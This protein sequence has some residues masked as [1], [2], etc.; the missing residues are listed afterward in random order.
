M[1]DFQSGFE[2]STQAIE[3][4]VNTQLTKVPQWANIPGGLSKTSSSS[5]AGFVWGYNDENTLWRCA[6][7]C[8]GNWQEIAFNGK[9][10]DLTTDTTNVYVL[11]DQG[12]SISPANGIQ[13]LT[14]PIP[15]FSP[16]EVFSTHTFIWVQDASGNKL[17]CA[18]PC[19]AGVWQASGDATV[20]I[21]STSD[22]A[23]Y[24]IDAGGISMRTDE[25]MQTGWTPIK[26]LEKT[27]V[28]KIIGQMDT[29]ALY[30]IDQASKPFRC[31]GQDCSEASQVDTAGYIPQSLSA[32]PISKDIWMTTTTY[33][34]LG[35]IFNRVDSPD[36]STIMNKI[37][38][39]DKER[40]EIIGEVENEYNVQ[41]RFMVVEKQITDFIDYFKT[42]FKLSNQTTKQNKDSVGKLEDDI[43][44]SQIK[45]DTINSTQPFLQTIL[46]TLFIVVIM[47]VF[48]A[49]IL[50]SLIHMIA[51]VVL[52][53]GLY[54]A[55]NN[56]GQS[57]IFSSS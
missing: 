19:S 5:I 55:M 45:L 35:N 51:I 38:P 15:N 21:T 29:T 30:G 48:L 49:S 56:N 14:I 44:A 42:K 6:V 16:V 13:F 31:V 52:L 34:P 39:L 57:A 46:V 20:K 18:K 25:T 10:L 37:A 54:Y 32:D 28:S 3:G 7:P 26:G 24:G 36:Y 53:G 41:T 47:Y 33:A 1:A 23:L 17:R 40:Q 22:S 9:I 2:E 11:S 43:R 27:P 12:L 8:T 50:G 4:I